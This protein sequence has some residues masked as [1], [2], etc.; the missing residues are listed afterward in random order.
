MSYD[1][2]SQLI[3]EATEW[4]QM[5]IDRGKPPTRE[6]L[7]AF[8]E[9]PPTGADRI[10]ANVRQN[11]KKNQQTQTKESSL[12]GKTKSDYD[13][14]AARVNFADDVLDDT[15]DF[16]NPPVVR[17]KST[18][19]MSVYSN[20]SSLRTAEQWLQ[21]LQIAAEFMTPEHE[22][23]MCKALKKIIGNLE[24]PDRK[25]RILY[26]TNKFLWERVLKHDGGFDFLVLVGFRESR[27]DKGELHLAHELEPEVQSAAMRALLDRIAI[28]QAGG[29]FST[30]SSKKGS[31][32]L[33][34]KPSRDS[35]REKDSTSKAEE[36]RFINNFKN[37]L[38][39]GE[40]PDL[41][42]RVPPIDDDEDEMKCE[43]IEKEGDETYHDLSA[44]ETHKHLKSLSAQRSK[45]NLRS[46]HESDGLA[47]QSHSDA[48][49]RSSGNSTTPKKK[50]QMKINTASPNVRNLKK[51][52]SELAGLSPVSQLVQYSYS[53]IEPV[54]G[55]V[56]ATATLVREGEDLNSERVEGLFANTPIRVVAVRGRR[57]KIDRPVVGWISVETTD[58]R[59]IIK[60][61]NDNPSLRLPG[62]DHYEDRPDGSRQLTQ[63]SPNGQALDA[64]PLQEYKEKKKESR[65]NLR[66]LDSLKRIQSEEDAASGSLGLSAEEMEYQSTDGL[67]HVYYADGSF[68]LL[69]LTSDCAARECTSA[70]CKNR[71]LPV[72]AHILSVRD[73]ST[74]IELSIPLNE[75]EQP[76]VGLR[77][78]ARENGFL[79]PVLCLLP[80]EISLKR[81][82]LDKRHPYFRRS[83]SESRNLSQLDTMNQKKMSLIQSGRGPSGILQQ[84]GRGSGR[85][86]VDF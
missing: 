59:R 1:T 42:V 69:R 52:D 40:K 18:R 9:I 12:P 16:P 36:A 25:Y 26:T 68:S 84:R 83:S 65:Q 15:E 56:V 37:I 47:L 75:N 21:A 85:L 57:A 29:D 10:L 81:D 19:M 64:T 72:E 44:E 78:V 34:D 4:T 6:E 7:V 23:K 24:K 33:H 58:G 2:Y 5:K 53:D 71:R 76:I 48:S 74:P 39:Q 70:I 67:K 38:N 28:L 43:E 60:P 32:I 3:K 46:N 73:R 11:S 63:K 13:L 77:R 62:S 41:P 49:D 61:S 54:E 45:E 66:K 17:R 35:P 30:V 55:F 22:I 27:N 51:Q 14:N 50:L 31:N 79:H 82:R 20:N 8:F 86:V 80:L